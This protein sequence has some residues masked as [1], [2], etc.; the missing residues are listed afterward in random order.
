MLQMKCK[1]HQ[2]L[3]VN[4]AKIDDLTGSGTVLRS[5][6]LLYIFSKASMA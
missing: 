2:K 6:M 5:V 1:I 4:V 3:R